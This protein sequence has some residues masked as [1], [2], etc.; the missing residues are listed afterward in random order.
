VDDFT[1]PPHTGAFIRATQGFRV[2]DI[3]DG[4]STT[5]FVGDRTSRQLYHLEW[6]LQLRI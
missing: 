6:H 5:F 4:L 3:T 2:A 1:T